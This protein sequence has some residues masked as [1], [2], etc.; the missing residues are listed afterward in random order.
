MLLNFYSSISMKKASCF[1]IVC[2]FFFMYASLSAEIYDSAE[3]SLNQ[4]ES[5]SINAVQS[6]LSSFIN[7][8]VSVVSGEFSESKTDLT[9]A[10]PEALTFERSYTAHPSYTAKGYENMSFDNKYTPS[11]TRLHFYWHFNHMATFEAYLEEEGLHKN[12]IR[13]YVPHTGSNKLFYST[14]PPPIYGK[15]E[16]GCTEIYLKNLKGIT[17]SHS[18][19]CGAQTNPKIASVFYDKKNV[20]AKVVLGTG[21]KHLYKG[22]Y[23]D[24]WNEDDRGHR[25][26]LTRLPRQ[27]V[28]KPNG[29]KFVYTNGPY[30]CESFGVSATNSKEDTVYSWILYD[31]S[32][33][34]FV[35]NHSQGE[36][37]VYHFEKQTT[38]LK[39]GENASVYYLSCVDNPYAPKEKFS[40]KSQKY[41][42]FHLLTRKELPDQR[43]LEIEYF[44]LGDKNP[45]YFANIP[46]TNH[47]DPKRGRVK[48]LKAPVGTD[49]TPITTHRFFY[50]LSYKTVQH[51]GFAESFEGITT[52]FDALDR[53]TF[54]FYD[55]E[56]RIY[57]IQRFGK[58]SK[59]AYLTEEYIWDENLPAYKNKARPN[60]G[61][62]LGKYVLDSEKNIQSAISFKYDKKGNILKEKVYGNLSGH[63]PPILLD[64]NKKPYQGEYYKKSST[65]SDDEFNLLLSQ[66]EDNGKKTVYTYYPGTNLLCS[67]CVFNQGIVCQRRFFS[68]DDR[69]TLRKKIEDDG[70]TENP[71]DLTGVT[72]RRI[73]YITPTQTAPFGLPETIDEMYLDLVSGQEHLLSR[74]VCRYSIEGR[75]VQEDHYDNQ[76]LYCYSLYWEYNPHGCITKETNALGQTIHRRYDANDNLIYEQGPCTEVYKTHTYD[77]SN[78]LVQTRETHANGLELVTSHAY[79]WVGNRI[80]TVDHFG[81]ETTFIYDDFNRLISTIKPPVLD[82]NGKIIRPTTSINYDTFSNPVSTTDERG[83]STL[84]TFNSRGKPVTITYPDGTYESFEYNLD[85]SLFKWQNVNGLLTIYEYDHLQRCLSEKSLSSSGEELSCILYGYNGFRLI[86]SCDAEGIY[87]YLTHD[88]AGRLIKKACQEQLTTFEYDSLGR[89][90][91]QKEWFGEG[92]TDFRASC[93]LYDFL[94]RVVEERIED[95]KGNVL[96][97]TNYIY[98]VFGNKSIVIQETQDGLSKTYTEYN[99]NNLPIKIID[100]IGNQT[101]FAYQFQFINTLGQR[102]LQVHKTNADG[103]ILT[104]TYDALNRLV[105]TTF[106][107]VMQLTKAQQLSAYDA[108]GN[109]MHTLDGVYHDKEFKHFVKTAWSYN[110]RNQITSCMQ[111]EGTPDQ[112]NTYYTYNCFGQK[113]NIVKPDGTILYHSYDPQGRL[114]M[115]VSTD[116]SILYG[117]EYNRNNQVTKVSDFKN[118]TATVRTYDASGRLVREKL[119]ND[120]TLQFSYDR[121]N[122][123]TQITFKNETALQYVYNTLFLKEVHRLEKGQR[124]YSHLYEDHDK[125]GTLLRSRLINGQQ[126]DYKSDKLGRLKEIKSPF[127]QQTKINYNPIGTIS[128]YEKKDELGKTDYQFEYDDLSHLTKEEGSDSDTY[129]CDSLHN[130]I[131]H[132]EE[133]YKVNQLNQ[134]IE[135]PTTQ[136]VYDFNGNLI[137]KIEAL[138]I[139]NY[140]YDAL[141]RLIEISENNQHIRFIYDAFHRRLSKIVNG[142]IYHYLYQGENEVGK[143]D[144][145]GKI[146]ELRLLGTGLGAEIGATVAIEIKDKVFVPLHDH[147]GHITCLL[148]NDKVVETYRYNAFGKETIFDKEGKQISE[149]AIGN[150]W[151]FSSKRKDPE[152]DLIYFGRR[153]YSPSM[154]KWITSDPS[155]FADGIN[156]YTYLQHNPINAYDLYGLETEA[157]AYRESCAAVHRAQY[158]PMPNEKDSKANRFGNSCKPAGPMVCCKLG[159]QGPRKVSL[160]YDYCN[161]FEEL[162]DGAFF[163]V[164]GIKNCFK[165]AIECARIFSESTG[166]YKVRGIYNPTQGIIIDLAR[167]HMELTDYTCL[168]TAYEL[169]DEWKQAL[170]TK[171]YIIQGCHSEGAIIVRNALFMISKEHQ[172]RIMVLAIAPAAYM[173]KNTCKEAIHYRSKWDPV[174][175][176]DIVGSV[177][178]RTNII[179]LKPHKDAT[180]IDHSFNSPTYTEIMRQ[181]IQRFISEFGD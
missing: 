73:T 181:E 129:A 165:D 158:V 11:S 29:N 21:E 20:S 47:L 8:C 110:S 108:A 36:P 102:V 24:A 115:L 142:K 143:T 75:P 162:D 93:Y 179:T 58:Q 67:E 65:Y 66:K 159:E 136:Y 146:I 6:P 176:I 156:L 13:A 171:K 120:L 16:N 69:A 49:A 170:Q 46:L 76:L 81:N 85:G 43:F 133:I 30:N 33:E 10:G 111:A 4:A 31:I 5:T 86:W 119:G 72:E 100:A 132:N 77:F 51:E 74:K 114:Q 26:L 39:N 151:R 7:N 138:N 107:N 105:S 83:F 60:A 35:I 104:S 9:L 154:G 137:K 164:N 42:I 150:P 27:K 116:D 28:F 3:P 163:F 61:L 122:R 128:S 88:Q 139:T 68:Y 80:A 167:A 71:F 54:Y 173:Y 12:S 98:D 134:V 38:H 64:E 89:V 95:A 177:C 53:K 172:Q 22:G 125:G 141:D 48:A 155:G 37:L 97:Q 96:T 152:T 147:I 140:T 44:E 87:T 148:E 62:L 18:G 145:E 32:R 153:Y 149:S 99:S 2:L 131:A 124:L 57:S 113:E 84:K 117:Y 144:A 166:G 59:T 50:D 178:E 112:K 130:R 90:K 160:R 169:A 45:S 123:P 56:H 126:I 101:L 55:K 1:S 52:V 175:R 168:N 109:K 118:H 82:E 19:L 127:W 161:W 157:Y 40:Y 106:T 94:D 15:R 25:L 34:K 79:D 92:A 91:C 121:L 41:S 63:A 23:M 70:T 17:N 180:G 174:P 78:R 14:M 135:H 103:N